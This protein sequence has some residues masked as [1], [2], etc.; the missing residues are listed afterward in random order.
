MFPWRRLRIPPLNEMFAKALRWIALLVAVSALTWWVAGG[1]NRGWT[2]TSVPVKRT[3]EVT[4]ISVDD[5]QKRFV[6]GLDFLG[7]A[8]AGAAVLAGISFF[9]NKKRPRPL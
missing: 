2:K 6:P 3:D 4:G 9:L 7:A 8:L 5:Y 1:A